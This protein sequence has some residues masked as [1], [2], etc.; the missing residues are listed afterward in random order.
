MNI[1]I[2]LDKDFEKQIS[3]LERKYGTDITNLNRFRRSSD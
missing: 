3:H 2:K 1:N